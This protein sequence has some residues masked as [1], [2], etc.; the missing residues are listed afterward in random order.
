MSQAPMYSNKKPLILIVDDLPENLQVLG[1]VLLNSGFEVMPAT[2]GARALALLKNRLPD[3]LL[4]DVMMPDMDGF[5]VCRIVKAIPEA[6]EIPVIFL[7][8]RHDSED[9][10]QGFDVGGVDYI[11]KPFNSAELIVRVRTH[12]ELKASRDA[13]IKYNQQLQALNEEKNQFLA[14][15]AHDL[16]SPLNGVMLGLDLLNKQPPPPLS[17]QQEVLDLCRRSLERMTTIITNLLDVNAIESGQFPMNPQPCDLASVVG[18]AVA[19]SQ[20]LCQ[21]KRQVLEYLRPDAAVPVTADAAAHRQILDNLISN[22]SKF[23]ASDTVIRV[24]LEPGNMLLRYSVTDQGPGLTADDQRQLFG[25]FTRL[26]AMPTAGEH[27]T[28]LGLSIVKLMVECMGGRVGCD[29]KPGH[30]A[31]FWV[32]IPML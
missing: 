6:R 16:K 32:E 8:A 30:G 4:L 25:K 12:L 19:G 23:S 29:S 15:A 7:T 28:G 2:S 24:S 9:V 17:E 27:S 18:D 1:S 14:I 5:E 21:A 10:V 3:L 31:T 20:P 26:S 11:T 13:I 22:A